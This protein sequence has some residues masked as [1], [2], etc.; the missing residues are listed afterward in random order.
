MYLSRN[1][2]RNQSKLCTLAF[3]NYFLGI[4]LDKLE[5]PCLLNCPFQCIDTPKS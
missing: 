5:K 1:G 3:Y 2:K 4:K